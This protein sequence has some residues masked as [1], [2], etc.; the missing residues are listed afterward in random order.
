MNEVGDT[1]KSAYGVAG[2]QANN[3]L[4]GAGYAANEVNKFLGKAGDAIVD[5]GKKAAD[6]LNPTKW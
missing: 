5:T 2:D 6:T 4:R 3:I 1:L